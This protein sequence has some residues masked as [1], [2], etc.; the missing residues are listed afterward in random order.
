MSTTNI[1]QEQNVTGLSTHHKLP[2]SRCVAY[3][4][5]SVNTVVYHSFRWISSLIY[6]N[7]E[8]EQWQKE[9]RWYSHEH[10]RFFKKYENYIICKEKLN[11]QDYLNCFQ[12]MSIP[13]F[14]VDFSLVPT[15]HVGFSSH[16]SSL[17]W[18]MFK[19]V[20][21]L[22]TS[23]RSILMQFVMLQEVDIFGN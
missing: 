20:W 17:Y 12:G 10:K 18:F 5:N 6:A 14:Y 8:S 15:S 1:Y 3:E 4:W 16:S 2:A 11:W 21:N 22:K 9:P 7:K 19:N 13:Q 23:I